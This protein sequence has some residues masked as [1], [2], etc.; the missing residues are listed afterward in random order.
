[1]EA[2]KEAKVWGG[3][4]GRRGEGGGRSGCG[5]LWNASLR[6]GDNSGQMHLQECQG[7]HRE[8][9]AHCGFETEASPL[10]PRGAHLCSISSRPYTREGFPEASSCCSMSSIRFRL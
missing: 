7:G 3:G 2:A 5:D 10:S 9:Q 8:T 6:R 1:M 4:R